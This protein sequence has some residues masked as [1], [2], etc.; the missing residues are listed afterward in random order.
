MK[1][2]L[3]LVT[4]GLLGSA[5]ALR[6]SYAPQTTA[7][8]DGQIVR[9]GG[10]LEKEKEYISA[11]RQNMNKALAEFLGRS[12][13]DLDIQG[14]MNNNPDGINI[15]HAFSGGGYRAMLTGAGSLAA[16]D[17]RTPGSTEQGQL[18]G[19]FQAASY[20]SGLSGGSWLMTSLYF[21]EIPTIGD[22][23]ADPNLWDLQNPLFA[24]GGLNV[25]ETM[26]QWRNILSDVSDKMVA[27]FPV[28]ITDSW[29]RALARQ[30]IGLPDGGPGV[31]WSD[32]K[33]SNWFQSQDAPYPI[34]VIDGMS[35]GATSPTLLEG[36]VFEVTPYEL[37]SFD[38]GLN[39]FVPLEYI[40]SDLDN[41][42]I[43]GQCHSGV[44]NA[45]FITGTSS[46][47]FNKAVEKIVGKIVPG[48]LG[49]AIG[50]VLS[51]TLDRTGVSY[52]AYRPNP[53]Q[54]YQGGCGR[55]CSRGVTGRTLKLVDGGEDGQVI[56]FQPLLHR[57]R[58]ID[59]IFTFDN[60]D[61]TTGNWQNVENFN[62]P[63]GSSVVDTQQRT[64]RVQQSANEPITTF[65]E[66]PEDPLT[67]L[68]LG[69]TARPTFF[70]CFETGSPLII[71]FANYPYTHYSNT[72]TFKLQYDT[73]E[74]LGMVNN[75]YNLAT[76]LNGTRDSEWSTCVAC[77]VIQRS[78]QRSEIQPSKQCQQC[79]Q[80]YCW[81][82]QELTTDPTGS[83]YYN[84]SLLQDALV[85]QLQQPN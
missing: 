8:P 63:T 29:G 81:N 9:T 46:S 84:P 61:D 40:G 57:D 19:L 43:D 59:V 66:V 74:I 48:T 3:Q 28:S 76:Q 39:A 2:L 15:A 36:T 85:K 67:F 1:G 71:Y 23:L 22:I 53:F 21:N 69:L 83:K 72:S 47:V 26:D 14:F 37:G 27:G 58:N 35:D 79:F 6:D 44:D 45:G 31:Q 42:I 17:S 11:R 34:I 78:N 60:N 5:H 4:L 33:Q 30:L 65:P 13:I 38:P 51:V 16:I 82:K 73:A 18:G 25:L 20:V 62:W 77:A 68:N 64:R 80:K 10:I 12:G 24:E 52:G 70:G 56:P 7:C 55:Q 54:N 50:R 75:G 49:S 32:M 41:G